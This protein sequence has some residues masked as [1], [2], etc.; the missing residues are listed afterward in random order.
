MRAVVESGS[1]DLADPSR[2]DGHR[3][4]LSVGH[5]EHWRSDM[6]IDEDGRLEPTDADGTPVD[7]EVTRAILIL[8]RLG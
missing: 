8:G 6:R 4:F 3:L 7:V 5:G 2:L 1:P